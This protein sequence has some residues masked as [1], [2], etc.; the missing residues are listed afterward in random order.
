[1]NISN[2][3]PIRGINIPQ[4]L[5]GKIEIRATC[6]VTDDELKIFALVLKY[7]AVVLQ[8]DGFTNK[9]L[10]RVSVIFLDNEKI[11]LTEDDPNCCGC[12]FTLVLYYMNKLRILNN[13]LKV[14]LTFIE[15]LVHHYWR[16]SDEREVKYKDLEIMHYLN[17]T[18]T[19][20]TLKEWGVIGCE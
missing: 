14:A 20:E 17:N 1:M 4:I 2:I 19:F 10:Q 8:K 12:R 9:D 15:E 11:E 13:A 16:I 7:V 3:V 5:E 18:V 6:I